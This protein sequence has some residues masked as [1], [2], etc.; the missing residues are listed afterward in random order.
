M[1]NSSQPLVSIGIP[2]YNR[3]LELEN[4]L[5]LLLK[6]TYRNIEIIILDNCSTIKD[7]EVIGHKFSEEHS[8]I[9]YIRN[10]ENFGVLK[11]TA[12]CLKYAKGE[13]FCWVS[14]DDWRSP[15]FIE[16]LVSELENNKTVDLAF[17]DYHEVYADGSLATDYPRSHLNVFKP[18]KN[19][20][21]LVRVLSFYW[22]N[23]RDGKCN[24]LYSV[25]RKSAV[26]TLDLEKI[27]AGFKY[28][29]M[30]CLLTFSLLQKGPAIIC[31]EAMC[32]LTCGNKKYYENTTKKN[33][34]ASVFRMFK[35]LGFH[36][37]DSFKYIKNTSSF[38]E[39][40]GIACLT[41]PK[42]INLFISFPIKKM[43]S[44]VTAKRQ[45]NNMNMVKSD[46]NKISLSNVTLVALAT[47]DVE[48]T[49]EAIKYS[50]K[51]VKYAAVKLLSHY[52]PYNLNEDID[53]IRIDK[54]KN[55]DEWSYKIV[56]ELYKYI[57]T[58]FIILVHAD[59]FVVNPEQ[60]KDEFL[61]YDYIGAPWPMPTD[62]FSYRDIDGNIIRVGNSVSLRS[63]RLLELPTELNIPWEADHGFYN[64]DGFLCVKNKHILEKAGLRFAPLEVAKYFSHEV[65][66][67]ELKN[68]KPFAFHKWAG[69]NSKYPKF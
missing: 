48:E 4:V 60:W 8:N 23:A 33:Q 17:C 66:I 45:E 55:I 19:E 3:P 59:G 39:K 57:D 25:F 5:S 58:D 31:S 67:P 6:Q 7:V 42:I 34:S 21:R 37:H 56:Y 63:K 41:L 50:C 1:E 28:L 65:M 38:F 29:N 52:Q 20:S 24:F 35:F 27:S 26:D 64:E 69:T 11:N 18:F 10:T 49:V 13:Y 53:F 2:T 61:D 40:I 36:I 62:T 46:G 22:Q 30:D 12:E 9:T 68:I 44:L 47:R 14:D 15:E 32:T 54:V 43:L 51:G 16:L